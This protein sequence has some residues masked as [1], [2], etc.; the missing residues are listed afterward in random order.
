MSW[1][2]ILEVARRRSMPLIVTDI[3]GREPMV[4]L[5]FDEFDR[6]SEGGPRSEVGV[7]SM[8]ENV[9][10]RVERPPSGAA[11]HPA[12]EAVMEPEGSKGPFEATS[13]RE[14]KL[15]KQRQAEAQTS[16]VPELNASS[17][18]QLPEEASSQDE[19]AGTVSEEVSLEERFYLEPI[20]DDRV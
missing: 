4:I 13:R 10:V 11:Y 7:P 14:R 1:Q 6:L 9:P 20:Q 17:I 12:L 18:V 2:R 5:P 19:I 15:E 16:P 8:S 3:M